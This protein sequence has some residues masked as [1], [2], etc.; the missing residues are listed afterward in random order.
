MGRKTASGERYDMYAL[1]AAH[2]TLPLG[3]Q[4]EV[5]NL[6]NGR[7]IRLRV[8]DRGPFVQGRIIDLSYKAAKE[9]GVAGPGTAP[10][11]VEAVGQ[12]VSPGRSA[13]PPDFKM[14]PFTVQVGAFTVKANADRLAWRLSQRYSPARATVSE[15]DDGT[16]VFYRVRIFSM[17][18]EEAAQD[19]AD[20]M[21]RDGFGLGFVVA[22]D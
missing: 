21:A 13:P 3:T 16:R 11:V 10:V 1:T 14:G 15:F 19:M 12:P 18:T 8:N 2:K 17:R 22:Q 5:T 7:K 6:N 20:G 9:L 4:V